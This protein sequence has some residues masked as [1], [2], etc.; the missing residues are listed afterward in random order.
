[1]NLVLVAVAALVAAVLYLEGRTRM[2]PFSIQ[3]KTSLDGKM[4]KSI[5]QGPATLMNGI[6]SQAQKLS[7]AAMSALPFRHKIR[8]W[9][10]NMKRR[11]M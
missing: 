11:N 4:F 8:E 3:F 7:Y 10:R 2:E 9:K 1:M 6:G 5:Q